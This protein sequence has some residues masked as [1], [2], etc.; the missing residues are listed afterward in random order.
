MD[1]REM[2]KRLDAAIEKIRADYHIPSVMVSVH[3]DGESFFCG[4]GLANVETGEKADENTI[5]AIAS[6][7]KAFIATALCILCDDGRLSLDAPVKDYLPDFEMYDR[8]MT[9]HLT[10]RDALGHRSGLPRHD[11]LWLNDR[12]ITIYDIV[13]RLRYLPPAF[14]PRAR[15]HYQNEMFTLATVLTEKISGMSWHD[16]VAQR[17]LTPLGMTRT[18]TLAADYRGKVPNQAEPYRWKD[19]ALERMEYNDISHLGSCGGISS[20]VHDLDLW[21]RL[22]LGRGRLGDV[23]VFSE[24]M[25]DQLHCPQMII[26]PGEMNPYE[27]EEIDFTSY[28]QGWFIESYRG[29]KLV[30]HGG[31][32]DGFKSL[33]GFL[34]RDGVSFSILT[35]LNRNQSPVALGYIICDLALG[36]SE[37]DWAGRFLSYMQDTAQAG[38]AE[39]RRIEAAAKA[40]PAPVRPAAQYAGVYTHPGY[41]RMTISAAGD[42]MTIHALGRDLP[43]LSAGYDLF[44]ADAR[45]MDGGYIP[46]RFACDM[47]GAVT[48]LHAKLEPMC[49][50]ICFEKE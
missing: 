39:E 7:S 5:Y 23:R 31:T 2:Q 10:V 32:I 17:I 46:L 12:S 21:S 3:K 15:M 50:M 34:P 49:D 19:G 1:N 33:V 48:A 13:H 27:F 38:Q 47:S 25:A 14:E 22:N 29:H 44:Y 37:I 35:N 36:L 41:G 30:H 9:Y 11:M 6:A 18:Y 26:K 43:M 8:Y 40:A 24:K 20:T 45:D 4:G 28:G 42:V 16:F